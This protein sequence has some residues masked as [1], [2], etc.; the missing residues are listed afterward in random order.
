M[1]SPDAG[2]SVRVG[3]ELKG[4]GPPPVLQSSAGVCWGTFANGSSSQLFQALLQAEG[5]IFQELC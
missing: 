2:E 3:T 4:T 1:Q 5:R